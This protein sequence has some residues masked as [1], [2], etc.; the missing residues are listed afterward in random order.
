MSDHPH[1]HQL[2]VDT[3]VIRLI[4]VS[5]IQTKITICYVIST[6]VQFPCEILSSYQSKKQ[7]LSWTLSGGHSL[8]LARNSQLS[9][10][11][12]ILYE[13]SQKAA[14]SQLSNKTF[15]IALR[16]GKRAG[17]WRDQHPTSLAPSSTGEPTQV[18]PRAPGSP[19]AVPNQGCFPACPAESAPSMHWG[20]TEAHVGKRSPLQG[21]GVTS[22]SGCF[23]S[24]DGLPGGARGAGGDSHYQPAEQSRPTSG[25]AAAMALLDPAVPPP[26]RKAASILRALP[27]AD[28]AS[29]PEPITARSSLEAPPPQIASL[30][31]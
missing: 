29:Q 26:A 3:I 20:S 23:A 12:K 13:T 1:G 14:S 30:G 16:K 5:D 8:K 28:P 4:W 2:L 6:T 24:R 27:G 22:R 7:V 31:R 11:R 25:A 19:R 9:R 18:Q 10:A 17:Y 15:F 21:A